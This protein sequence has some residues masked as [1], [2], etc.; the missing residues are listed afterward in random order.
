MPLIYAL[1]LM[2]GW[3]QAPTTPNCA[4]TTTGNSKVT[5]SGG[6]MSGYHCVA[7]SS[8]NSQVATYGV[9]VGKSEPI[10]VPTISTLSQC[11]AKYGNRYNEDLVDCINRL[12]VPTEIP[13]V[14]TGNAIWNADDSQYTIGNKHWQCVLPITHVYAPFMYPAADPRLWHLHEDGKRHWCTKVPKVQP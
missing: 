10:D 1:A 7:E 13:A 4:I 11:Q 6:S 2:M 14:E 5:V 8:G 12:P 3:Q 9:K